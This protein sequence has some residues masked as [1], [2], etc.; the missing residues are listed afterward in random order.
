[1]TRSRLKCTNSHDRCYGGSFADCP[2]CE[3]VDVEERDADDWRDDMIDREL[4]ERDA[5][6]TALNSWT[7][8][9]K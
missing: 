2:Y 9:P 3:E 6:T 8:P 5:W 7:K 1:M 4:L